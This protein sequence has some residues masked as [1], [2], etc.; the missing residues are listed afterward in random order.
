MNSLYLTKL[1]GH[2]QRD[3]CATRCDQKAAFTKTNTK[4][5]KILETKI[6]NIEQGNNGNIANDY[7]RLSLTITIARLLMAF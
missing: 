2:V 4:Y 1:G 7:H 6:K 5:R 3:L